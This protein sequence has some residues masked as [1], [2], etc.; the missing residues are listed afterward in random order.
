MPETHTV[1]LIVSCKVK[2]PIEK[3][4]NAWNEPAQ[5]QQWYHASDDWGVPAAKCDF[6]VG[7]KFVTTMAANDGSFSFDFEG[8][9]LTIEKHSFIDIRLADG[10][11]MN[12]RFTVEGDSISIVESF[13]AENENTLE[14]QKAGW[15]AILD[16]FKKYVEGLAA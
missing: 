15:Q 2:A 8:E 13:Q 11:A 10:R 5:V 3:V 7:G 4:W 9:Y 1:T 14:L 12:V 16:N 6:R